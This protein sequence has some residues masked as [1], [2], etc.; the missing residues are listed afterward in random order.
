MREK[1]AI[2]TSP[3]SAVARRSRSRQ[4]LLRLLALQP[5]L[6]RRVLSFR[7]AVEESCL[8]DYECGE[9]LMPLDVQER[10]AAFVLAHEPRLLRG[11]RRLRLQV[12]AARCYE[13]GD[14]VRHTT[15]PRTSPGT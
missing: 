3:P 12:M 1:S 5:D 6:S 13:S 8:A 2:V 7:L 14:V 15:Y 11:A 4:L 10:L 9:A